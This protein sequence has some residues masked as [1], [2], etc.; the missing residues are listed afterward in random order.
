M[1]LYDFVV[2]SGHS[3]RREEVERFI[4]MKERLTDRLGADLYR[5]QVIG[6]RSHTIIAM[7]LYIYQ[8]TL[9]T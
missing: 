7:V 2:G 1:S 5:A 6:K 8:T 3:H 4:I 9:Q